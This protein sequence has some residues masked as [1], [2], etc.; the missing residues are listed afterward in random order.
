MSMLRLFYTFILCFFAGTVG[1]AQNAADR[2][3]S[4][5]VLSE[6]KWVRIEVDSTAIYK[7]TYDELRRMGFEQP[8]KVSVYG[9]GGW[10]LDEKILNNT[11]DDLPPVAVWRGDNYLLFYGKGTVKWEYDDT[12]KVKMF[13]HTRNPYSIK[14]YYFLTDSGTPQEMQKEVSASGA[15]LQI[16]SYDDY[17]L[18]ERELESVN[19]SGKR[20][21]GESFYGSRSSLDLNFRVPGILNETGRVNLCFIAR[22]VSENGKVSLSTGTET[23]IANQTIFTIG[24]VNSIY[25]RAAEVDAYADWTEEKRENVKMTVTY[26]AT[27]HENARLD[28]VRIQMKRELR[29]YGAFTFFRSLSSR[30]NASRFTIQGANDKTRVFDVTDGENPKVMETTL[31]GSELSF[32]IPAGPLREFAVVQTDGRFPFPE[33]TE[34]VDPQD[35]HSIGQI[36]M[37]I[38]SLPQFKEHAGRLAKA[39]EERDGLRVKVVEPQQIYNEFS[40]GTPDATAY[41]RFMKMFWDRAETEEDQPKYLLLFGDGL[42]DNRGISETV[43]RSY[44]ADQIHKKMLLTYQSDNSFD[45]DSYVTD[46][47]FG[48]LEDGN[49][50]KDLIRNWKLNLGVGRLPIRTVIEA[51][52][53]VTKIINYMDN[54][55]TGYWKNNLC[56]VA[57]DG[58]SGD[59]YTTRHMEQADLLA[60]YVENSHPEFLVNKIYFDAYKKDDSG[61]AGYPVVKKRIQELLNEGVMLINYNGHGDTKSWS[62]EKVL[63]ESDISQASYSALPLWVTASCD[64]TRFDALTTSAGEQVFLNK[65]SG[66]IALYTT[67]RVVLREPNFVLNDTLIRNLFEKKADGSRR[68]LG[69]VMKETKN[70]LSGD[71]NK[72]NFILIGDPALKMGYPEYKMRVTSINGEP[73]DKTVE[74]KALQNVVVEGEV[75]TP[76][77]KRITDFNG[78]AKLSV[79]DSRQTITTLDNNGSV[80]G[81]F[82]Y[83]EYPPPII[84]SNT[85]VENGSFRFNFQM[86]KDISYSEEKGKMNLYG[87]CNE[88]G[89]EAQGSFLDFRMQGTA[90][91]VEEDNEGPEVLQ[92]YLNDS[93][94]VSGD[95]VNSTPLFVARLWDKSGIN[96]SSSSIGHN[97]TLTIDGNASLS[98]SLNN[99]FENVIDREGESLVVFSI[100]ALST[101]LHTAEFMVW[102]IHNN[103]TRVDFTFVVNESLKP[104]V[105]EV[106]ATPN[107]AREQVEFH[108]S[109][110]RPSSRMT[111]TVMVYDIG[112]RILWQDMK[113]GS[114]ELFNSFVT[115]WNLTTSGGSRV[116]PG[117]YFYRAAITTDHSKEATKANKL[118]IL[119]Q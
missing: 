21:F 82:V 31:N 79:L 3:A 15:V 95:E 18:H 29:P 78:S 105:A 42:Y 2:Y 30:Q 25:T 38:I 103:S 51:T 117:I 48:F 65:S 67:T 59:K 52:N 55:H 81:A 116:R 27:N 36:D 89:A 64:F 97:I 68:T 106:F 110:N 83:Q 56:F 14:G 101:G 33:K 104:V 16:N 32:S 96:L 86:L 50:A 22:P 23:P 100:P 113:Q 54:K 109:H 118:I 73:V 35:L 49:D 108:I 12:A 72:L 69:E 57:D 39:H 58:N 19:T 47:Y 92:L 4:Q 53:G 13:T 46:D 71:H 26:S 40:S 5:S 41:R 9:Y 87:Y 10:P 76:E 88:T 17:M 99:Y 85:P 114:S 43:S 98:Y 8:E 60:D 115:D 24:G 93:T 44:P 74:L 70:K 28:Y 61:S 90:T 20:L 107:P 94:F 63:T 111:V 1:W 80:N 77:G 66:G 37:A 45:I 102:D 62:D 91:G 75:I 7:I 11:I 112:G 119:A 6:G 84:L 34:D